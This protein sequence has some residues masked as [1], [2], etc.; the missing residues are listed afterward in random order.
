MILPEVVNLRLFFLL[1]R[2]SL[3]RH[4]KPGNLRQGDQDDQSERLIILIT[5]ALMG[6]MMNG[7]ALPQKTPP[8][9]INTGG[10]DQKTIGE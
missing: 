8:V 6:G 1:F 5:L 4:P 2:I 10:V 9:S 7:A 3:L